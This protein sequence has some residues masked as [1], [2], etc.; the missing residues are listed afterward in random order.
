MPRPT[1]S[2]LMCKEIIDRSKNA[3]SDQ[4]HSVFTTNPNH[5]VANAFATKFM[6]Y[7]ERGD[8]KSVILT[9]N[10]TVKV[11]NNNN[12]TVEV[13]FTGGNNVRK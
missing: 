7:V 9:K 6:I 10:N 5:I 1:N 12:F 2:D 4:K 8:I 11:T 13:S 3:K